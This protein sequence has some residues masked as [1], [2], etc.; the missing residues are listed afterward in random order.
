LVFVSHVVSP[1]CMSRSFKILG[2]SHRVKLLNVLVISYVN[3]SWFWFYLGS[4]G[5]SKYVCKVLVSWWW[6]SS[7]AKEGNNWSY[8]ACL[9]S[10]IKCYDPNKCAKIL[11]YLPNHLKCLVS[12]QII[13]TTDSPKISQQFKNRACAKS[14]YDYHFAKVSNDEL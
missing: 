10:T 11:K 2:L 14:F 9:K 4:K 3:K 6:L 8:L 13:C 7:L 5:W 1:S 12:C